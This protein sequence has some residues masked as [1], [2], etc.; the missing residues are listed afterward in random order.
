MPLY[1]IDK[2]HRIDHI[3]ALQKSGSDLGKFKAWSAAVEEQNQDQTALDH[4][5]TTR[6]NIRKKWRKPALQ[7]LHP[8]AH[9]A[10]TLD[11][12]VGRDFIRY[13]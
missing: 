3:I 12:A 11:V 10:D 5:N 2:E 4:A 6:I 9:Q 13:T 1:L 7:A 8:L